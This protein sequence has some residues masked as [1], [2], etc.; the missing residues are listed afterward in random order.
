LVFNARASVN[1]PG[2]PVAATGPE[3]IMAKL[4][5]L[6]V[7]DEPPARNR[8]SAFLRGVST[9][10]VAGECGDGVEALG[11]IRA[12][13]PDI[14]FLDV[15][16]PG[17]SG[18]QLIANLPAAQRPAIVLVTAHERFA[19]DAFGEQVVDYLL[20]PFDRSRFRQA[21]NRA[22]D[23]VKTL[24]EGD[25]GT[26]V[27]G[28][29]A[30]SAAQHRN[31]LVVRVDGRLIFLN[32]DDIVWIEAESNYSNLHLADAKRLLVRETL[33]SIEG[34]LGTTR[35][36]RVNRSALVHAEQVHELQPSKYGDYTVVLRDGTRLPLS[37][38]LRSRL[39]KFATGAP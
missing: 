37:R 34:R 9:V 38:S 2:R 19:V 35:F 11:L 16:M 29:L 27:E 32:P 21:L 26:R 12:G 3:Q 4:Q 10:E 8:I 23:Y 14:V 15:Q 33:S 31:R 28:L 7:D 1:L 39:G 6:I 13:R 22:V 25:L 17:C 36:T 24:R 18:L 30:A 5:I 20:K